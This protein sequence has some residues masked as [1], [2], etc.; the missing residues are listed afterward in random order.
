M[1]KLSLTHVG[2]LPYVDIKTALDF[3]FKFDLPVLFSLPNLDKRQF[4]GKDIVYQL[5]IGDYTA[6]HKIQLNDDF[7]DSSKSLYPPYRDAFLERMKQENKTEF[8]FQLIGPITFFKLIGNSKASLEEV[9]N[10]LLK[11][12]QD[13]ILS[14][15]ADGLSLFIL[16][17]PALAKST[18]EDRKFLRYF[19]RELEEIRGVSIGIHV[20]SKLKLMEISEFKGILLNL[21]Y[22]L[23]TKAEIRS[24]S[25]TNFIGLNLGKLS[26]EHTTSD[27]KTNQELNFY[28]S[29]SC[30]LCFHLPEEV[31][32]IIHNLRTVKAKFL[33]STS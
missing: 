27:F 33:A 2:S 1:K 9:G 24:M 5:E 3:T 11:K 32:H 7:Q 29:P 6:E 20:C 23:Y 16:D 21:D 31:E 19:L 30:G 17:E 18:T 28:L 8:K 22:S 13:L 26:S 14:L 12:Y 15:C 4:M 10:F 25:E